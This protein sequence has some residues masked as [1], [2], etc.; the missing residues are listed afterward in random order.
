[1]GGFYSKDFILFWLDFILKILF[2][3]GWILFQGFY[4]ILAGFYSKDFIL[5]WLDFILRILFYFGWILF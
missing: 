1:L 3:F 4:F 5:F 2:Y